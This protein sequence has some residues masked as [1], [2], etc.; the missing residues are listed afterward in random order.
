MS[1]RRGKVFTFGLALLAAIP[2]AACSGEDADEP[3]AEATPQAAA[4]AET[5]GT[6]Q[7]AVEGQG[8][9]TIEG[10]GRATVEGTGDDWT[11]RVRNGSYLSKVL[12]GMYRE[13]CL[14][15]EGDE[16]ECSFLRSLL[17]VELTMA[18]E[19]IERS[20]DQRGADEALAALQLDQEPQ[21]LVAALRVLGQ[22]PDTPGIPD[23]VLPLMQD[24]PWIM[25]QEL[26]ARVLS[27]NPDT[28]LVAVGA[29]WSGNHSTIYAE[30]EYT[31]YPDFAPHYPDM[32]FPDYPDAEWFSPAD[33]DRSVGWWTTDDATA[34]SDWL[35]KE[36]G[37]EPL[38]FLQ[39]TE[40]L[41]A[42]STAAMNS[43]DPAK[44]AEVERLLAEFTKT[45]NIAVLE[46]VQKLQ[47]EMYA[48]MQQASKVSEMGVGTLTPPS[49]ANAFETARFFIAEEKDG[50]IAR[51][52]AI[53]PLPGLRRTVIQ[54]GWNLLD[55]P[56]AWPPVETP[57]E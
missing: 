3:V 40:R 18:L 13:R 15:D 19:E 24:S 30:H 42:E 50:H 20:R 39:W 22:F 48:P 32:G 10:S 56:S 49:T 55:Y 37:S 8:G 36:L 1:Q 33:S 41:S 26:A 12:P 44:Q 11:L 51:M 27:A 52:I 43:I 9:T 35:S 31:E 23:K 5:T 14:E 2:I 46:K 47:E 25:V 54:E 57:E 4:P 28:E 7:V 53:Y 38:T 17:V 34:V 16:R 29:Y 6:A 45:Q 21:V